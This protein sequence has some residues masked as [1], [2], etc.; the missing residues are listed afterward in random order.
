MSKLD[1]YKILARAALS[2]KRYRHT[3][4]TAEMCVRLAE[5]HAP[6][7]S[8]L[9]EKAEIAGILHD[10]RKEVP[11]ELQAAE[12]L[13]T[14]TDTRFAMYPPDTEEINTPPLHHGVSAAYYAVTELGVTDT[15][16]IAAIRFHTV[17]RDNMSVLEKIVYLGDLVSA[18]RD[19]KNVDYYRALAFEDLDN[20]MFA[21]FRFQIAK[22]AEKGGYI[23]LYS[24]KGYNYYK[25][26][27]LPRS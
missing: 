2:D 16:I 22:N 25:G 26:C 18:E 20:A 9:A 14:A 12:V 23:P 24:I 6:E 5:K 27:E 4:N 19:F 10:I 1:E 7:L 11:K 21:A 17:G 15:D 13:K 8:E 3:L